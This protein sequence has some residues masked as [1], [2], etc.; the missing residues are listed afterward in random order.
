M[1][2]K[3]K[4]ITD[5]AAIDEILHRA[6]IC[7]LGLA[8]GGEPYVVPLCFGYD[9]EA[10][11]FHSAKQGRKIDMIGRNSRVCFEVDVDQEIVDATEACGWTMKYISVI[12]FGRA[13][14]VDDPAEKEEGLHTLMRHYSH[15]TFTMAKGALAKTLVIKV[16]IESVAGKESG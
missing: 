1:R 16:E 7:R 12:G 11:F 13:R 4:E 5:R 3:E 15:K 10:L 9:G 6:A 2:R 14:L 8:D